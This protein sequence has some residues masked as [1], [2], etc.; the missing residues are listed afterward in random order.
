[1]PWEQVSDAAIQIPVSEPE[2][3]PP[4]EA[5]L[6][7]AHAASDDA[8]VL[9]ALSDVASA[10]EAIPVDLAASATEIA[11]AP[12]PSPSAAEAPAPSFSWNSVFD[13]AWKFT[14]G[15]MAPSPTAP[16]EK[17]F[18]LSDEATESAVAAPTIISPAEQEEP[19]GVDHEA[20]TEA[21]SAPAV[22]SAPP[23]PEAPSSHWSTGEVAVQ[24]HRPSKKKKRWDK[25]LPET[26][27]TSSSPVDSTSE[28]S[29]NPAREWKST[30][31]RPAS[32]VDTEVSAQPDTRPDWMQATEAIT[33][34]R[35]EP[36]PSQPKWSD[37]D[38]SAPA[39]GEAASAAVVSAVDTL[40]SSSATVD[41]VHPRPS[42][43][44][45]R[46]RLMARLHRV[47]IAVSSLIGYC[48]STTR[49]LTFLAF[50]ISMAIVVVAAAAIGAV[51]VMWMAMEDPPSSLYQTLTIS[52]PR[53]VTDAKKNGY[54]L[55]LGFDAPVDQDPV[56][57][58]YERR[59]DFAHDR[60]TAQV[61]TGD[62]VKVPAGAG[63][64]SDH[65]IK[66]W[67]RS[68]DPLARIKGQ[69]GTLKSLTAR[70][71]TALARYQQWLTMPFDD[72]GF[73]QSL[74]PNCT[75][76]LLA[77]RL[78][79]LEGFNQDLSTGL[80]RL[81]ADMQAWRNALGQAKTLAMK[82]LAVTAV[83]DDASMASGLLSRADLD[84]AALARL[85]KIIRPLDQIELSVRWPLQSQF[86]WATKSVHSEMKDDQVQDR[87]WHA[88]V[89][90]AMRLPVQRRAN[91]YADYYDA[92][93]KAVAGGRYTNLPK[94]SA[95]V[96]T[97]AT[98]VMDYLANPVEHIVG[99]EPLP[100]WDPY[101]MRMI[102]ADAQLRL[103]GLQGWLR[104]GPQDGDV[105]MRLA[106]AGQAY[107]DPF[108]G[109]PMLVNQQKG[110]IY[111]VGR[112]G[113]DQEGDDVRDVAAMIPLLLS[114][115][116]RNAASSS[117]R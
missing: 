78:F 87:P 67:I 116:R 48:F 93:N 83:Q 84:G 92:A 28:T 96:R 49:S 55:L 101:V 51:A 105:H 114:E 112:D 81:E 31:D 68:G 14:A 77:H 71:S 73:G 97:P 64:A 25:D 8:P 99:I 66:G 23:V 47:R 1:M 54:L 107:Y 9:Q 61:C 117:L 43:S 102:E 40:F 7:S 59:P 108:T 38:I 27:D 18:E 110:V 75:H 29:E 94:V 111:S 100:S 20:A 13:K 39:V 65:V 103:A 45:P 21:A 41:D 46:P 16:P 17:S 98:G 104:R 85:S 32:T 2:P 11:P 79:V 22:H 89:A 88:S 82:M 5:S 95:Y 36:Q 10:T 30:T 4:P 19:L 91:A 44:K 115:S 12:E 34:S 74:S 106:K 35:P 3:S 76:V 15:T 69:G 53:M 57:A 109:L 6:G 63:G 60:A 58:G 62:D 50:M 26:A 56:E 113:K 33:F 70:E 72:W 86:V 37:A 52:P 80:D 42:W 90:A 24:V